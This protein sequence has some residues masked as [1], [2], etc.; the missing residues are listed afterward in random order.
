M[1]LGGRGLRLLVG[2]SDQA[3]AVSQATTLELGHLTQTMQLK[4]VSFLSPS[5]SLPSPSASP[6]QPACYL[7]AGLHRL[8]EV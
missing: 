3:S 8:H 5:L 6:E 7:E 1:S 4:V 2:Y